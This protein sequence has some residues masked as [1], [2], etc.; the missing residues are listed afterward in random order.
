MGERFISAVLK[1]NS[2]TSRVKRGQVSWIFKLYLVQNCSPGKGV[3]AGLDRSKKTS[4]NKNDMSIYNQVLCIKWI[5]ENYTMG[6]ANG[7]PFPKL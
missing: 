7:A 6:R 5:S 1:S 2:Q 4:N 3:H